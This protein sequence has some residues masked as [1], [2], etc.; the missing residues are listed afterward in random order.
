[1]SQ[2]EADPHIPYLAV[3]PPRKFGTDADARR[4]R[5][6]EFQSHLLERM[7]AARSGVKVHHN[8]LGLLIGQQRWLLS[9]EE[10]G[11]IVAVDRITKVPLTQDWY[12][13]LTNIRGTL[14]SVI[15]F[16]RYQGQAITVIDKDTRIVAFAN[17]LAF[18]SGLLV[19]RV[20]GLR[21]IDE[22]VLQPISQDVDGIG[23]EAAGRADPV[24]SVKASAAQYLDSES[25]LWTELKLTQVLSSPRFLHIG[26]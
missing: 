24:N 8:Q 14:I 19:S 13:G 20:L 12:L 6:R 17:A 7:E 26:R 18:N 23:V 21:N 9:L 15:D 5:L 2:S 11:E 16:A 22:M 1:M 10:A 25:Q 4:S 3:P